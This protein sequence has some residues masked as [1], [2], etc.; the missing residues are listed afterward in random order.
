MKIGSWSVGSSADADITVFAKTVNKEH[1][2]IKYY[3]KKYYLTNINSKHK[4]TIV[5]GD[6]KLM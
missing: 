2:V 6:N 1:A 4:T 5:R 3:D